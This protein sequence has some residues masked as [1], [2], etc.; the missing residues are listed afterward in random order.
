MV[1]LEDKLQILKVIVEEEGFT[2]AAEKLYKSQPS[3]S[4]DIKTL[5]EK[6]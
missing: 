5:E 1:E 6:Y 3:I 2:N 4:R